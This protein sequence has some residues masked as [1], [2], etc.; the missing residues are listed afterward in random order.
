MFRGYYKVLNFKA[1]AICF[2]AFMRGGRSLHWRRL[3]IFC[4]CKTGKSFFG[5]VIQRTN[6]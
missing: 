3:N 2:Y 5:F 4:G 1:D 6:Y